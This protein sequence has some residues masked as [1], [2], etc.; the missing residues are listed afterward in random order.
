MV[1]DIVDIVS[2][3][4]DIVLIEELIF[5]FQSFHINAYYEN[6]RLCIDRTEI[7]QLSEEEQYYL[8]ERIYELIY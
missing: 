4:S 6:D 5:I 8:Y 1:E 3:I 2:N 7:M